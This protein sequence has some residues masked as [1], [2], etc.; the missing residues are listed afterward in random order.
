MG[1]TAG[2]LH[3]H[4][5]GSTATKPGS[6]GSSGTKPPVYTSNPKK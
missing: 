6:G 2:D 3:G 5:G 4:Q 1:K